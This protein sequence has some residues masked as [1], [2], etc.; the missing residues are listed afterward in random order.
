M[1]AA[2]RALVAQRAGHCCEYCHL[3]EQF[4]PVAFH[5]E[6]IIPRQHGGTDVADN[7]SY[8]CSRCNWSK[9]PNLSGIDSD[10][11]QI[12]TLFDPRRQSWTDHFAWSGAT[13]VGLT[14]T[15]RATVQVLQM[16]AAPRLRLRTRLK[17]RGLLP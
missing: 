16:N 1:D 4:V 10:T 9:G 15:G 5:V 14:P 13:I 6:H 17:A 12:V 2:L 3:P 7:L 11:G 8:S